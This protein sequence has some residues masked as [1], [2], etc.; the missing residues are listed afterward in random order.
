MN[1][2]KDNIKDTPVEP[3]HEQPENTE[4]VEN[5]QFNLREPI[6]LDP[7]KSS[8]PPPTS[9][10]KRLF[11]IGAAALV[12]IAA[13][14]ATVLMNRDKAVNTQSTKSETKR[15]GVAVGLVEGVV[16]YSHDAE[17]WQ[18]AKADTDLKEGDSVRTASDGRVVLLIDDGSAVRLDSNSEIKLS[19]LDVSNILITNTSGEV[20]SRVVASE[21]RAYTVAVG[22]ENY[23]AK[24]TA[25]RTFNEENK[26]GVEVFHS[27]VEAKT[28]EKEVTEGSYLY[29]KHEQV[30][31]Q[32]Q[33]LALDIEAL[34]ADGFI[35]WNSEQDKKVANY[36]D[37]LGIL[38]ELDKPAPAPAPAPKAPTTAGIVLSGK[39]SEYS[40]AFSWKVNGIDTSKGYKLV[41]S[42]KTTTPT[43]PGN[44]V[45]YIDAGKS[46]YTLFVGEDMTYYYRI[47][48]YRS[49]GCESYSNTVTVTTLKK[50][51][52]PVVAGAV[53]AALTGNVLSWSFQGTAPYGF[54]IV[55]GS[56]SGPT[57]ENNIK[58][59]FTEA[60]SLEL[61]SGDFST[62][63]TYYLKVCKY[64]D[65][66][67]T[68]Y[69][70]EVV[71]TP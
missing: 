70:N 44:S 39:Q 61:P 15:F 10:R 53:S 11:M 46:S 38:S 55:V 7:A 50:V 25:Y 20:Y 43:Y 17:T 68:D 9:K 48:A 3:V 56:S 37:K 8:S 69:S 14:A 16:Q 24:G 47:C 64:N 2:D 22:D 23:K 67:C 62:G 28:A 51:K 34:K 12:I 26:K 1:E 42:S 52:E 66:G 54:K 71:Y 41:R 57:Y 59:Y 60:T 35:K 32:G 33:V 63:S 18:D 29:S 36:A 30:D 19:S 31:K 58:K 27:S 45:A 40:A 6:V 49:S 13:G 65:G 5:H 4:P 21:T